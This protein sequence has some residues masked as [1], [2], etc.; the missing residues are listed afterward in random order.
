MAF[1]FA[2]PYGSATARE[3]LRNAI[4]R[5]KVVYLEA[6]RAQYGP[7]V[8]RNMYGRSTNADAGTENRAGARLDR[9]QR[10]HS[11]NVLRIG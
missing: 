8:I 1:T 9:L 6:F 10:R 3:R 11:Q 7:R 4:W 5:R 2:I